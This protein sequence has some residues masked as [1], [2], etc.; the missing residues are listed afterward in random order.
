MK[1]AAGDFKEHRVE[2]TKLDF[3]MT[4]CFKCKRQSHVAFNCQDKKN[5]RNLWQMC[6]I[7]QNARL[8]P[9]G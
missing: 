1:N 4:Y 6:G 3:E 5:S 8:Y 7:A 9:S 2:K